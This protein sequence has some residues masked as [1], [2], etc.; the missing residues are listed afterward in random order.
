ML[1]CSIR[2]TQ[3]LVAL[4][5]AFFS[6]KC[7]SAECRHQVRRGMYSLLAWSS[8]ACRPSQNHL[9]CSPLKW[10]AAQSLA[11]QLQNCEFLDSE[12]PLTGSIPPPP[13]TSLFQK[14]H[15]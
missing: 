15:G 2:L 11:Q 4:Q 14:I 5:L 3:H 1:Q 12:A 6:K 7:C 8:S 10:R 13:H 9:S